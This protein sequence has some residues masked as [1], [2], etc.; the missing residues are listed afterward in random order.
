MTTFNKLEDNPG[1]F[2]DSELVAFSKGAPEVILASCT[3]IFL[4]GE[5]KAL[6][7]EQKQEISEQVKELA[8][9]ALRVMA[10]SFRPLEE[11]FSPEN[12]SSGE[13]PAE[14]VEEDMV[15]SGLIWHE[16][17]S[18]RRSKSCNQNL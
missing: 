9:Q 13:I 6:I 11:D 15:F 16:R 5:M 17:P 12:V 1:N 8:D 7:P 14:N 3:K 10:L 2:F 18:Q 4:N